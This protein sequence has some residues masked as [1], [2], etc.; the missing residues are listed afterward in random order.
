MIWLSILVSK[1]IIIATNLIESIKFVINKS[2]IIAKLMSLFFF[3]NPPVCQCK[4]RLNETI[5]GLNLKQ[6]NTHIS[7]LTNKNNERSSGSAVTNCA[8]DGIIC[9]FSTIQALPTLPDSRQSPASCCLHHL[10]RLPIT[11]F[12]VTP[13]RSL[14][15]CTK[16]SAGF[17]FVFCRC[18]LWRDDSL[19]HL[20]GRRRRQKCID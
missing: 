10:W 4:S 9:H 2:L 3:Y 12:S 14:L 6:G 8:T 19:T 11:S 20:I 5:L 16:T 17:Y 18:P 1:I 15:L 7:Y 13:A